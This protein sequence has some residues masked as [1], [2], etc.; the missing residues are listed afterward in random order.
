MVSFQCEQQTEHSKGGSLK[1]S[2]VFSPRNDPIS[3]TCFKLNFTNYRMFL[4]LPLPYPESSSPKR[5]GKLGAFPKGKGLSPNP[6]F[7]EN[8]CEQ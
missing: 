2:Y 3:H 4:C 6:H 1:I 8:P 5:P 7:S